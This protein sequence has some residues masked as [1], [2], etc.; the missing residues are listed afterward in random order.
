VALKRLTE[1]ALALPMDAIPSADLDR[2]EHLPSPT[3]PSSPVRGRA[4][5]SSRTENLYGDF[6]FLMRSVR[7]GVVPFTAYFAASSGERAMLHDLAW[8]DR[9]FVTRVDRA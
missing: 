6:T 3:R 8:N 7:A 2:V 9:I 1:Y 5:K 4:P